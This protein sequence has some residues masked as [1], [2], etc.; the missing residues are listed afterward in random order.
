VPIVAGAL[1]TQRYRIYKPSDGCAD[2]RCDFAGAL[3]EQVAFS[4]VP[5]RPFAATAT[6]P[7]T[8]LVG[9]PTKVQ[10]SFAPA[11]IAAG[12]RVTLQQKVDGVW[13]RIAT[14]TLDAKGSIALSRTG[15]AAGKQYYRYV[16]GSDVCA[17]GVCAYTAAASPTTALTI[18]KSRQQRL[19]VQAKLSSTTVK[20]GGF[21]MVTGRVSPAKV[22]AGSAVSLRRQKDGV[23][24]YVGGA[25]IAADGTFSIKLPATAVGTQ[26]YRV[27]HRPM[28]CGPY[29]CLY[30]A[31]VSV[32]LTLTVTR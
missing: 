2:G 18:V 27:Y 9:Q 24:A 11:N 15:T 16:I 10:A 5:V 30:D 25:R 23:L 32:R 26:V 6:P 4:V 29:G 1:G 19:D 14:R 12:N 17:S 20:A 8:A 31:D 21:V 22:V 28:G 13:K 7:T 3:S